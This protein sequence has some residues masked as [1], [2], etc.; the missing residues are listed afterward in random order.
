MSKTLIPPL[1]CHKKEEREKLHA[2]SRLG[3]YCISWVKAPFSSVSFSRITVVPDYPSFSPL[4]RSIY[5]EKDEKKRNN[6]VSFFS[7]QNY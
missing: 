2:A 7:K 1:A 3:Q 5:L 6:Y 4:A